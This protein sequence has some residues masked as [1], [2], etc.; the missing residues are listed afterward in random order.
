MDHEAALLV[1]STAS[2]L[3]AGGFTEDG[4]G[5]G[6]DAPSIARRLVISLRALAKRD[7]AAALVCRDDCAA[8]RGFSDP[9]QLPGVFDAIVFALTAFTPDDAR[10]RGLTQDDDRAR[11]ARLVQRRAYRGARVPRARFDV[12]RSRRSA[13]RWHRDFS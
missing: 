4:G 1:P 12:W 8:P 11:H 9:A 2:E 6:L 3:V 5:Y 10:A 7:R 13:V